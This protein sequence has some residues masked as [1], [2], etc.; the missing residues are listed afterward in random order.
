VLHTRLVG[1]I[2]RTTGWSIAKIALPG[3]SSVCDKVASIM[4]PYVQRRHALS[5]LRNTI[6]IAAILNL[7]AAI[8]LFMGGVG[9]LVSPIPCL[10]ISG[11]LAAYAASY[12]PLGAWLIALLL[13]PWF[14]LRLAF[15]LPGGD[16]FA[17]AFVLAVVGSIVV[18]AVL[19]NLIGFAQNYED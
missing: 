18:G 13:S 2:A 16:R 11:G 17:G 10:L 14:L 5:G 1:F 8:L 6:I 12:R 19:G 4:S 15:V 9:M 7:N 3:T